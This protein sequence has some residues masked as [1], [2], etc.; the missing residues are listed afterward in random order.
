MNTLK[1]ETMDKRDLLIEKLEEYISYLKYKT[2]ICTITTDILESEI[3]TLETEIESEKENYIAND[4]K[5]DM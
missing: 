1:P 3:A 4:A 2:N 5:A